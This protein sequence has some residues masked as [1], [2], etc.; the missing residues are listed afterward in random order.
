MARQRILV[1]RCSRSPR[2]CGGDAILVQDIPGVDDNPSGALAKLVDGRRVA[3][4]TVVGAVLPVS[5]A[6]GPDEALRRAALL[7][8]K[9]VVGLGVA[10]KRGKV[11]VEKLGRRRCDPA[12]GG[13]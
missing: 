1:L 2:R 9:L 13:V 5:Y 10:T 6:R 11:T 3:G 8:P 12:L 4:E 7:R